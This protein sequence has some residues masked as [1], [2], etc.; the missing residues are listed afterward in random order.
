[1]HI[2]I[3]IQIKSRKRS[4]IS[5]LCMYKLFI[6]IT[7]TLTTVAVKYSFSFVHFRQLVTD[8]ILSQSS[9]Y[10]TTIIT[11]VH[12]FVKHLYSHIQYL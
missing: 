11:N 12:I 5:F 6:V 1:M 8:Y 4:S 2:F 3:S 7:C 10:L 9:V